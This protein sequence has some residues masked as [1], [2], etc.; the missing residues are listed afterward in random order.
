MHDC[1]GTQARGMNLT[2]VGL[3]GTFP[4][5]SVTYVV[6]GAC[7]SPCPLHGPMKKAWAHMGV[8]VVLAVNHFPLLAALVALV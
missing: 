5:L 2:L 1:G 7:P 4:D 3:G 8:G 6:E